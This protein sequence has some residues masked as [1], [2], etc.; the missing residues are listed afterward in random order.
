MEIQEAIDFL[1]GIQSTKEKEVE[2]LKLAREAL[3]AQF[4]PDL[5]ELHELR[6]KKVELEDRERTLETE[7]INLRGELESRG[8]ILVDEVR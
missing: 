4:A 2:C 8:E 1:A 6:I 5:T 3:N 7:V